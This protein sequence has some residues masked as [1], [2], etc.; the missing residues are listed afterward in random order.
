MGNPENTN[1]L[2]VPDL[3]LAKNL[4]INKLKTSPNQAAQGSKNY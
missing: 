4:S 1:I 3:S 2:Q